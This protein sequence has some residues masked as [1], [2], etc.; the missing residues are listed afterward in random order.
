MEL[1]GSH[2]AAVMLGDATSR[3]GYIASSKDPL[4]HR[5][6]TDKQ[7][8]SRR[9]KVTSTRCEYAHA[10]ILPFQVSSI[11]PIQVSP[12]PYAIECR[13]SNTDV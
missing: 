6:H 4:F 5:S 11:L 2:S 12:C 9:S 8:K 13:A 10:Q 7:P 1:V 3:V